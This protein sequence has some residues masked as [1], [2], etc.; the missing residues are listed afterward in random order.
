MVRRKILW[1]AEIGNMSQE[2]STKKEAQ[3]A[4]GEYL[5]QIAINQLLDVFHTYFRLC[6][7]KDGRWNQYYYPCVDCGK[8]LLG[9]EEAWNGHRYEKGKRSVYWHYVEFLGGLRCDTCDKEAVQLFNEIMAFFR[10]NC[11]KEIII[12]IRQLDNLNNIDKSTVLQIMEAVNFW[13]IHR[14][15]NVK[16]KSHKG[17]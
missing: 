9:Y 14:G 5:T 11:K 1:V 10:E 15:K 16:T 13:H 2:F 7:C 8:K 3:R 6:Y 12:D 17:T 4:E